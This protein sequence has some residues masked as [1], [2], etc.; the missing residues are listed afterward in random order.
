M[1]DTSQDGDFYSRLMTMSQEAL[2]NGYYEAAYHTLCASLHVAFE[3]ADKQY[4]EGVAQAAQAQ[5]AWINTHA[6]KHKMST[7]SIAARGGVNLYNSLLAQVRADLVILERR[8]RQAD[9]N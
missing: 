6:P 7:E 2:E 3:L 4:L 1:S 9:I 8:R 5:L